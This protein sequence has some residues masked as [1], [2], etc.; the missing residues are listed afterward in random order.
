MA[1]GFGD[2][3]LLTAVLLARHVTLL[4]VAHIDERLALSDELAAQS[5]EHQELIAERHHWR[6]YDLLGVG[7]AEE[8][9]RE[10]DRL[11]L[12]ADRLAQ[13]LFRSI[14]AG[15]RGLFADLEGDDDGADRW[16]T[17]F[18][19]HAARAHTRDALSAWAG[20]VYARRRR[21]GRSDE[22]IEVVGRLADS[23]GRDLGWRAAHGL[24]CAERGDRAKAV[25][26]LEAEL[27]DGV[28]ALP[29]GMFWLTRI[30]AL[31][32]LA[33]A[34][35]DAPACAELYRV[36]APHRGRQVVVAYCAV[37]GPVEGYLSLLA[38]ATGNLDCAAEHASAAL[39]QARTMGAERLSAE[40]DAR[41][42]SLS[43]VDAR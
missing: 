26:L 10:L 43:P 17:T 39:G 14:A 13:P 18:R 9:Q 41:V 20:Q 30:A 38:E 3:Q 35:G 22:L 11:E 19:G 33:V 29:R 32:E 24:L 25:E 36:L 28:D 7:R 1:R 15:A 21:H 23:G 2:A 27:A 8:A 37:W 5:G 42:Q 6:M 16:A 4:D 31:S 34:L 40:L 12:L